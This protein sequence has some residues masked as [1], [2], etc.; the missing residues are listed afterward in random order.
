MTFLYAAV[1]TSGGALA[2][3][4]GQRLSGRTPPEVAACYEQATDL[5]RAADELRKLRDEA[6]K[7]GEEE[8]LK[9]LEAALDTLEE[10]AHGLR[11]GADLIV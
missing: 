4:T 2:F 1:A 10:A 6:K 9:N 11:R 3:L 8:I 7:A 5:E